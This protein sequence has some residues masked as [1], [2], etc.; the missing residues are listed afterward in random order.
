VNLDLT[1]EQAQ[2]LESFKRFF[3]KECPASKVRDAEPLGFDRQ[4]WE[5]TR[6]QGVLEMCVPREAGG[7]GASLLDIALI[8]EQHGRSLTP[9]PIIEAQTTARALSRIPTHAARAALSAVLS[10]DRLVTLALGDERT[11][12]LSLVPGGAIA[13]QV[14]FR[15]GDALLMV[16]VSDANRRVQPNLGCLPLAD[17]RTEGAQVLSAGHSAEV[18]WRRAHDEWMVLTAAALVGLAS[19]ALELGCAYAAERHQFGVPIATFQAISHRLAD[20]AAAID[21]A[22]LLAYEAAWSFSEELPGE[23][24]GNSSENELA[25]ALPA[26]ALSIAADVASEASA[27][28]LHVHGGYGFMTEYAIQLYFRRA[29]GWANVLGDPRLLLHQVA[30]RLYGS[31]DSQPLRCE[32]SS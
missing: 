30:D 25:F 27:W 14:V 1:D 32:D 12:G 23:R 16:S 11:G 8:A 29:K 4:L 21:G 26:M 3:E 9:T 28:S 18:L 20:S 5:L 22:R 6:G 7:W 24:P 19:R 2:L 17:L 13:D 15:R 10:G 31:I